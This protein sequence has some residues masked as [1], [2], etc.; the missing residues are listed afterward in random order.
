MRGSCLTLLVATL[1]TGACAP[2]YLS[3]GDVPGVVGS[4]GGAREVRERVPEP[5]PRVAA[6]GTEASRELAGVLGTLVW[7]L[8][9]D[10]AA[11]LSSPY[12]VR[13]HP[14]DR[15]RRFHAGLDLRAPESTPVYAAADGRVLQS[16][17]SGAYG[18]RVVI[19]HGAGLSSL[20]G[21]HSTNLV[22]EGDVVRRGQV[23]GLVGHTGNATG[24]HLHFELRWRDGNVDPRVVLPRLGRGSD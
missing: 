20:Y 19:D 3:R 23:I 2:V 7:P 17:P 22:G 16:G 5:E 6:E 10:R 9:I 4:A 21:H 15:A 11:V 1:L 12:G 13:T 18:N 14:V 8:A 24:D